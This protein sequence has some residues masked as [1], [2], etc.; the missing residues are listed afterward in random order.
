MLAAAAL[1]AYGTFTAATTLNLTTLR[2][3]LANHEEFHKGL[4]V[5][6]PAA[7]V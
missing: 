7:S 6:L 1:V 5:A 2:R 4:S 3:T